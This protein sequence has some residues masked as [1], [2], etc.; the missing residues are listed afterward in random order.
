MTIVDSATNDE[1]V[2][3]ERMEQKSKWVENTNP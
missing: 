1:S 3:A 2:N